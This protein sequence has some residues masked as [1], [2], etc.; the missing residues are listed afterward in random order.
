MWLA[1]PIFS[2]LVRFAIFFFSVCFLVLC[3][4]MPS[5]PQGFS[6]HC[7]VEDTQALTRG[8]YD[9]EPLYAGWEPSANFRDTGEAAG[10]VTSRNLEQ[11]CSELEQLS[12]MYP[13][14]LEEGELEDEANY[15]GG[16][17]HEVLAEE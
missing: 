4:G 3:Q 17:L 5:E 7:E 6:N 8:W 11:V 1:E 14:R 15:E 9:D 10:L 16:W 13:R 2:E 12:E